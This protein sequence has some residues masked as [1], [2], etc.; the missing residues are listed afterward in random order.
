[1]PVGSLSLCPLSVHPYD[2]CSFP[3][4]FSKLQ[5]RCLLN[6]LLSLLSLSVEKAFNEHI[7]L[8]L[9]SSS[10]S[11][12]ILHLTVPKQC[13]VRMPFPCTTSA[14]EHGG[15]TF[16]QGCSFERRLLSFTKVTPCRMESIVVDL[17]EHFEDDEAHTNLG[18]LTPLSAWNRQESNKYKIHSCPCSK[19]K[20]EQRK[21]MCQSAS[22]PRGFLTA[23]CFLLVYPSGMGIRN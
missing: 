11:C 20:Y 22:L 19:L 23:S 10:T 2:Q 9:L 14:C 21:R 6:A 7:H 15:L 8:F 12:M 13:F 5:I 18:W 3:A 1:M 4:P 17:K 16:I